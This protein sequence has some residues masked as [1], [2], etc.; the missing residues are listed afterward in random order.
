MIT[1]DIFYLGVDDKTIDLFKNDSPMTSD[2]I[3][4]L[5]SISNIN[6]SVPD[7]HIPEVNITGLAA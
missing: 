4:K 5:S 1:Q 7:I 6:I 3:D 2:V